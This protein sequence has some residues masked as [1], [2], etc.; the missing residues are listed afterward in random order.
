MNAKNSDQAD[1]NKLFDEKIEELEKNLRFGEGDKN[2][3]AWTFTSILDVLGLENFFFNNLAIPL[4]GGFGGFKSMH[5]WKGPCGAVC[6][7]CAAI[8]IIMGGQKPIKFGAKPRIYLRAAKFVH[9]F[10]KEFGSVICE[11]LCGIDFSDPIGLQK[12]LDVDIWGKTCYKYIIKAV[13]LV[14]KVTD[15]ELIRKWG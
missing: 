2:C 6:A 3:A 14:R 15:K 10:E 8:G 12:F 4:A 1:M 11:D 7:G 9:Y 5:G 13:D